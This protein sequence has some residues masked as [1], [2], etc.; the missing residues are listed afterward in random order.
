M[1]TQEFLGPISRG[2]LDHWE[3]PLV[4]PFPQLQ[5]RAESSSALKGQKE[6]RVLGVVGWGGDLGEVDLEEEGV[7]AASH[8]K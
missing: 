2:T 1:R 5:I 7:Q 4:A 3:I 6:V 8:W